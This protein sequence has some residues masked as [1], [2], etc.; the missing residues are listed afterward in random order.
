MLVSIP[1]SKVSKVNQ[2]WIATVWVADELF[3]YLEP[4]L[5]SDHFKGKRMTTYEFAVLFEIIQK[6]SVDNIGK[7]FN[8]SRF[9]DSYTYQLGGARRKK[10]KEW[11]IFYFN[12]LYQ[13]GKIQE[14]VV[15]PLLSQSNPKRLIKVF[16]L[17]VTRLMEPFVI[18]EALEVSFFNT[19]IKIL[20]A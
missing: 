13:E 20:K 8:I 12:K 14:Q 5:F 17:D 1:E 9:L 18:Y 4:F 15:F 7:E 6:F 2:R 10:M 19:E 11:F 3:D 16:D